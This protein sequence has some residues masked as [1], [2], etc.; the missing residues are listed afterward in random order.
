MTELAERA[1][2]ADMASVIADLTRIVG[3]GHVFA[4]EDI[5]PK[6]R[7]DLTAKFRGGPGAVVR[8]WPWR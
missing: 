7:A 8:R 6:H 3:A 4:G 5:E 2:P 1:R